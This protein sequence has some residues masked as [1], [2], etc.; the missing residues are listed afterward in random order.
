MGYIEFLL[1][2]E[3]MWVQNL[4]FHEYNPTDN[5]LNIGYTTKA[6]KEKEKIIHMNPMEKKTPITMAHVDFLQ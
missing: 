4:D 5:K 3:S 6:T 2:V 1:K